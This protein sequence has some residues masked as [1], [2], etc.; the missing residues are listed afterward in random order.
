MKLVSKEINLECRDID[1]LLTEIDEREIDLKMIKD[2]HLEVSLI[3]FSPKV[4]TF[5]EKFINLNI[6]KLYDITHKLVILNTYRFKIIF[7]GRGND[8]VSAFKYLW[9]N[10]KGK[11]FISLLED[12]IELEYKVYQKILF[13]RYQKTEF[14]MSVVL[15]YIGMKNLVEKTSDVASYMRNLGR[16][17]FNEIFSLVFKKI[18][19]FELLDVPKYIKIGDRIQENEISLKELDEIVSEYRRLLND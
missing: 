13:N 5:I 17:R 16:R 19:G 12:A 11:Y 4:I 15:A 2:A 7:Y 9:T 3:V 14:D 18:Y 10:I 8:V 6:N 1:K